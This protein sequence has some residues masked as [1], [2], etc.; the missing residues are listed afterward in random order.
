[1]SKSCW[2]CPECNGINTEEVSDLNMKGPDKITY[3]WHCKDCKIT[4]RNV[5]EVVEK[6]ILTGKSCQY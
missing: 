4:Y 6:N 2:E 5:F 3:D 1:M